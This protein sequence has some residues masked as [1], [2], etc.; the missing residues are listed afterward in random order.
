MTGASKTGATVSRRRLILAA[1]LA[2]VCRF[3]VAEPFETDIELVLGHDSNPAQRRDG[4]ELAF[5]RYGLEVERRAGL[6]AGELSA[7]LNAWYRDY[8]GSNDSSLVM[9]E[10]GWS[11]DLQKGLGALG[12]D[13]EG[14]FYR[15]AL[16]PA[17]ERNEARLSIRYDRLLSARDE[18]G[19]WGELRWLS[20]RNA[21]F[22]WQG[23]PGSGPN[24]QSGSG[25]GLGQG[26]GSQ[27]G[28]GGGPRPQRRDD[29]IA[30]LGLEFSR[31]WMATLS[32]SLVL[33]IARR[34][35]PVPVEAYDQYGADLRIR[36]EPAARWQVEAGLGWQW[37]GYDQAPRGLQRDDERLT[38]FA[39]VS[40]SLGA[41]E[42][43][44]DLSHRDN[45]SSIDAKSFRQTVTQ[46]GYSLRY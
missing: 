30:A 8:E 29:R 27:G 4:P 26:A 37:T 31:F 15:D 9:L 35:S 17:D 20:Y 18:L 40:R 16:V 39:A 44:C 42:I 36:F 34:E 45:A 41:G 33:N 14:G 43:L 5:A 6:G 38:A 12:L 23:R 11:R 25:S 1:A 32:S 24:L 7:G 10:A 2:A 3:A 19:L 28:A 22:P 46:C 13:L 21:S